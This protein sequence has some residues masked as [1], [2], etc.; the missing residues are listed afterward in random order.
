MSSKRA[1][2]TAA[3]RASRLKVYV[4]SAGFED[5][6]VAASSQAAALKAWGARGDLFGLGEAQVVTDPALTAEPLARPGE[7]VRRPRGDMAAMLAAAPKVERRAD[8]PA[9]APAKA[10]P[11]PPPP[12]RSVLERAEKALTA[13]RAGLE[14]ELAA[15]DGERDELDLRERR[16]RKTGEDQVRRLDKARAEAERAYVEAGGR[17]SR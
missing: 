16:A 9:S 8:K 7:V 11:A 3:P 10:A 14:A 12:D 5:A 2:A 1:G 13:A 6:Y 15:I 4:T 17:V